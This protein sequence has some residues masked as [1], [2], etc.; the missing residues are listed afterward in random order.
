MIPFENSKFP[1]EK[2]V[3]VQVLKDIGVKNQLPSV[4]K[5]LKYVT[6]Y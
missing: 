1:V 5:Q 2:V 3:V 6:R 4:L